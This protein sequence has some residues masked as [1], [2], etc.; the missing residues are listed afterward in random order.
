MYLTSV[1]ITWETSDPDTYTN[2]CTT[3]P[4]V[5]ITTNKG[6]WAS[7]TPTWNATLSD[8]ATAYIITAVNATSVTAT[9]VDVLKAGEGYFIK[10]DAAETNYTATA[11]TTEGTAT[12]GSLLVGCLESTTIDASTPSTNDKYILGTATTGANAG[13]SGLF[14]VDSS[15]TVGA[16]KAYLL[17]NT[18]NGARFLSLTL[19]DEE[20]TAISQ[21]ERM[22]NGE[23]ENTPMYNLAGQRVS[24]DYKGIVVV[25][26]RKQM[27]K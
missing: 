6:G 24:K 7:F 11:T 15:V 1:S 12:D 5:T 4:P 10:G 19:D 14:F 20:T 16:G 26:G 27:N 3:I 13:K 21:M 9:K 25:N 18:S 23:N 2:Y 17:S 22:R 8:G